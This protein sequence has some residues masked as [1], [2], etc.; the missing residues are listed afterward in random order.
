MA[1]THRA[2][3]QW[4]LTKTE[5]ITSFES[6]RQNIL[7]TLSLDPVFA[8]FL[9]EDLTWTKSGVQPHRGFQSDGEA[10]AA[11]IRC[12]ASLKAIQLELMLGQIANFCPIISRNTIVKKSESLNSVWQAIRQHYGFHTTG[13]RLLDFADIKFEPDERPE[14]LYQ[15]LVS[16][17]EDCLLTTSGAIAH[18][19]APPTVDEELTPTLE[20]FIVL[21]WLS[22]INKDLPRLVKQRYGAELRSQTLASIKPEISQAL[23]SLLDELQSSQDAKVFRAVNDQFFRKPATRTPPRQNKVCPLCQAAGRDFRHY[24]SKCKY[25]PSADRQFMSKAR[26]IVSSDDPSDDILPQPGELTA[27]LHHLSVST[28]RVQDRDSPVSTRRV[29]VSPSPYM[30]M[31]YGHHQLR[32]TI[33]TGAETN[34]IK[35]SVAIG[36]GAKIL[37]SNQMSYQADGKTQL[38]VIGEVHLQLQRDHHRFYLE[39]LVV[40][41]LDVD[42]LAGIPF[43]DAND[44]GVFPKRKEI[45]LKDNQV[46]PYGNSAI[47]DV[48]HTRRLT[49]AQVL[50]APA[51]PTTIWP[52]EYVEVDLPPLPDMVDDIPLALEPRTDTPVMKSVKDSHVWPHPDIVHSINGRVRIPNSTNEPITLVK[53]EHF[54]QVRFIAEKSDTF[55][56]A[57]NDTSVRLSSPAPVLSSDTHNIQLDPDS[58]FPSNIKAQFQALH[59]TYGSVFSPILSGYNG[60]SGPFKAVVNMGPVPPPQRKG[61]VP[62]YSKSNL[63]TLQLMFDELETQGIFKRP[64]DLGIVAEYLNPSFLVRKPSGGHRLVTAFADVGRYCKPQPSLMPDVDS[65]LRTIAS[66]N[67]IIVT[68]LL[69]AFYQIPLSRDSMKYCGVVTPFKGVR[70]YTRCAMGM[71]GSETALEELMCRILGDLIQSGSVAKIADDLYIGGNTPQDLLT[72]WT[73]VLEAIHRNGLKLSARKTIIA[74]TSTTILGWTW[75]NGCLSANPHR[76]STLSKCS[77]PDTVRGLRA[78]LGAYKVL[79]RVIPH[80]STYL[81]PLE[82]ITAGRQSQDKIAWTDSLLQAFQSSQRNLL[83]NKTISL[84]RPNDQLWIVTDGSVKEYGLGATLYITRQGQVKIAGFFSA[85]LK[86]RQFTWIPCELEALSISASIKH[87]SPYI[88]QSEHQ[89]C[90]LTDSKPC[91]QAFAKLCRGEFSCSARISTFLTNVS[92]YQVSIR[93]LSGAA[94]LPSDFASRHAPQCDLPSCQICSFIA[95]T[96][97]SVVLNI[98]TKDILSGTVQLPFTSRS[99]WLQTQAECSDIQRVLAHLRQGTRPS[100]KATNIKDI[101]R[102][103]NVCTIASDGLLVVKREEAFSTTSNC[104]V[105]PRFALYGLLTAL[106]LKL[107]H[108]TGHQ[109]KKVVHRVFYALDM[110]NA[111]ADVYKSCHQCA[112]LQK[113]PA[114]LTNQFSTTPVD[115]VGVKFAAD[116]IRRQRQYIFVL[117]E[118]V[119]SLTRSCIIDDETAPSLLKALITTCIDLIPLDGPM[120]IVRVDPAPGFKSLRLSAQLLSHRITLELGEPKNVNKN[121]IAERAVQELEVEILKHDPTGGPVSSTTLAIATASLNARIRNQGLS[122]REMWHQRDMFTNVQLPVSDATLCTQKHNNRLQNHPYSEQCKTPNASGVVPHIQIGDIVYLH[123]DKN[124]LKARDRYLVTD[125]SGSMCTVRK[126]TGSQYRKEPYSVKLTDCFKVPNEITSTSAPHNP[127]CSDDEDFD[128]VDTLPDLAIPAHIPEVPPVPPELYVPEPPEDDHV[129]HLPPPEPPHGNVAIPRRTLPDRNRHPPPHLGD[130]ELY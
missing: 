71:P 87:F 89:T 59:S 103:L 46:V 22:L 54:C 53:H 127:A 31:F 128:N 58:L 85:K 122:S 57:P 105:V 111:I 3:K 19:G 20:N 81:A 129:N 51:Y 101:K 39:A 99:A 67:Y 130:Y 115:S 82:D 86:Q 63:Q 34:L 17:V 98:T 74:P 108:P 55:P 36:M 124:K 104:I 121:P 91:V 27:D 83:S 14:D 73:S 76:I 9:V 78:F 114:T 69:S 50:R 113:L 48:S 6:W 97:D 107:V 7:Y 96:S 30:Y 60:A 118:C 28:R 44:I 120:A 123:S 25:L 94:N 77:P 70:V 45:I 84:P 11:A 35:E 66:W 90:L 125:I 52:G 1:A 93:H 8:K 119:T 116:V 24:L 64:E 18:C 2:P 79:A 4:Q 38:N 37:R 13:A 72:N 65:V 88:I 95:D 126:F 26:L 42:V 12:T 33:D 43:M 68:D 102:Y 40:S 92:R 49:I 80:C 41:N 56:V 100:K 109:L 61:R 110:D 5:T 29:Q 47:P 10:V 16:F 15:R 62:Q 117:R 106:H 23:D 32:L 21:S 112:S 75:R